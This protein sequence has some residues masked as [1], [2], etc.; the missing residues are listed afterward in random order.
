M[1]DNEEILA[2]GAEK[3]MPTNKVDLKEDAEDVKKTWEE[4][5]KKRKILQWEKKT[6][7]ELQQMGKLEKRTKTH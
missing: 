6:I 1:D 3:M 5:G 7:R 2:A 4:N